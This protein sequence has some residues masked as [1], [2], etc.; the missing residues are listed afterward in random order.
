MTIIL[1]VFFHRVNKMRQGQAFTALESHAV[2]GE[3]NLELGDQVSL[4]SSSDRHHIL[5]FDVSSTAPPT[6]GLVYA[7]KT[8]KNNHSKLCY[9]VP[10]F[11]LE[12]DVSRLFAGD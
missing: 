3:L 6:M 11:K 2:P 4:C 5:D 12:L 7:R 9:S 8:K 10:A 1:L